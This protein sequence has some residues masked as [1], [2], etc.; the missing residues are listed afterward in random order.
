MDNHIL[1]RNEYS[2]LPIPLLLLYACLIYHR[3]DS[4]RGTKQHKRTEAKYK[5]FNP[6]SIKRNNIGA[7]AHPNVIRSYC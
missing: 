1:Y 4:Y 6:N 5:I 3:H 7:M 2:R